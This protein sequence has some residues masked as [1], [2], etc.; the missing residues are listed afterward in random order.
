MN[1]PEAVKR[2]MLKYV[3]PVLVISIVFNIPKFLEAEVQVRKMCFQFGALAA[4]NLTSR[5][6]GPPGQLS[7]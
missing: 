5:K 1:S 2:R 7:A 3:I 6:V 4:Y